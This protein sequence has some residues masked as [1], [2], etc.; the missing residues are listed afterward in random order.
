MPRKEL[1][2]DES[3]IGF[4]GKNSLKQYLPMKPTKW[5]FKAYL[6]CEAI[7]GYCIRH[8]F[9]SGPGKDEFKPKNICT[10]LASGFEN[11]KYHIYIDNFYT[12]IP[13]MENF[14]EKNIGCTGTIRKSKKGLPDIKAILKSDKES[15]FIF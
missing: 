12:S 5:G 7:S 10:D 9:F 1:S 11:Q 6:L 4:K 14:H 2:I 8:K 15:N 3:M 13:L